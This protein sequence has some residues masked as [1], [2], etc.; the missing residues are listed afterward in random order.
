[1]CTVTKHG[2]KYCLW[3]NYIC[4]LENSIHTDM[5]LSFSYHYTFIFKELLLGRIY[6]AM[7][8]FITFFFLVRVIIWQKL[9]NSSSQMYTSCL[10]QKTQCYNMR[11]KRNFHFGWAILLM[12]ALSYI[13][14]F[15]SGLMEMIWK[16]TFRE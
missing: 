3:L 8:C 13:K 16:V 14:Q 12:V 15:L 5:K 2:W 6:S 10:L 9:S 11:G 1:M 7:E 4:Y